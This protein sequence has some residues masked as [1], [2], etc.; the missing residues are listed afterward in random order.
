MSKNP[1]QV[2]N[3]NILKIPNR[4]ALNEV[5]DKYR[6]NQKDFMPWANNT[7]FQEM[8]EIVFPDKNGEWTTPLLYIISKHRTTIGIKELLQMAYD[9]LFRESESTPLDILSITAN[10]EGNKIAL[11]CLVRAYNSD[12]NFLKFFDITGD[13][14]VEDVEQVE[15]VSTGTL[16]VPEGVKN[17]SY[18]DNEINLHNEKIEQQ[19][20]I[21]DNCTEEKPFLNS[22]TSYEPLEMYDPANDL[23][24]IYDL[25][26]NDRKLKTVAPYEEFTKV[27]REIM[28]YVNG[29]EY[30][31]Y[32][33]VINGD[34]PKENFMMFLTSYIKKTYVEGNLLSDEDVPALLEKL[35][36]SLFR[37]Y[38][39]QD[40]IDDP[41]VTDIKIT[42]P[43]SIR[44][45]V[46]GKAY[47]SNVTFI[48]EADYKRFINVICIRNRISQ[49]VPQQT[50]TDN[51]DENYI[52]RFS[53]L[54][55]YVTSEP[56]PYLHIRKID[57]NKPLDKE[58]IEAGMFDEKLRDYLLDCGKH[59]RG[60][61]FAGPPGSGKT[62][63]LN[64]FLEKAYEQSAEI[65]C[66]QE[67][68]ELFAYRNGVMFQHVVNYAKDDK[69]PVSLEELGKLALV[70]GANVFI[71]GEAKGAEICSA[72][73]LSNSGCRTAITIHS[74]SSTETIDKM[75]DLAMRGYA[76]D[77][78]QAKKMLRS[79]QTIVYLE[80][81]KI[82]EISEITGYN[83]ERGEMEYRYI[84]R[85]DA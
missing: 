32:I 16:V 42:S 25:E 83:E 12:F 69:Q 13:N 72:I 40:L 21:F 70:A 68:D 53:L 17:F 22:I 11:K 63:C 84:Y 45:R 61:V 48:D 79:F 10:M 9:F 36:R 2:K 24:M 23:D 81:F 33:N 43:T 26:T 38:V 56:W 54:A 47:I 31:N 49:N 67:N 3:I 60:V 34:V 74:P 7:S 50:F 85:R 82:K 75:A 41:N 78:N 8:A 27:F 76:K 5:E 37:L 73:T 62:V 55:E 14:I 15:V 1:N 46:K 65:L 39:V 20:R 64:W 18:S 57:R 71:I 44:A 59:S 52:L 58:L 4:E 35:D 51:R 19:Q 29:V 28:T 66:I 6:K 80:N 30:Y 77:I